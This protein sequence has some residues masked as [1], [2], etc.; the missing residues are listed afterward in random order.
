M[1][2]KVDEGLDRNAQDADNSIQLPE[3]KQINTSESQKNIISGSQEVGKKDPEQISKHSSKP[4]F[5]G[6]S[7]M[8]IKEDQN[9]G[10]MSDGG[11]LYGTIE[12][13]SN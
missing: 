4:K 7:D 13:N 3:S 2:L 11:V 9:Y 12:Q 10:V 8:D 1:N 5:F 6:I